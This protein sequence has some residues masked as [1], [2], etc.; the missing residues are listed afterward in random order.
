M[1]K[2][3][4][5][6][7][8]GMWGPVTDPGSRTMSERI[9]ELPGVDIGASPYRDYDVNTIVAA[10]L[11]LPLSV[12]VIVGGTSLG[13]NNTPVVAAYVYAQNP[14]RII[15]GIWGFQ[16]SEYG[17]KAG[18][19]SYY[20]GITPNVLFAHL[21][22]SDNPIPF[23]GLGSYRWKNAPGNN[24]TS[25]HLDTVDDPHPG[26]TNV[27]EQDKFLAE[28]QRVIANAEG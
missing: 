10:I 2:A 27:T 26:D 19:E 24:V 14:K 8:Y 15:Q 11:A 20:P 4:A 23:P 1:A 13:C 7:M 5:F 25:L 6:W 17:A 21:V 3:Y 22:S 9:A 28:M 18:V 16:A 12:P